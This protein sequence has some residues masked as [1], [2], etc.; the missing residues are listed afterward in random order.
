MNRKQRARDSEIRRNRSQGQSLIAKESR[1]R[2]ID[3]SIHQFPV[4]EVIAK[5][6]ATTISPPFPPQR[7]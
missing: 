4:G 5:N 2:A 1:D 6:N 7:M 3:F